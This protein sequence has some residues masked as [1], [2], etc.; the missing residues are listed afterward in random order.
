[1]H[2]IVQLVMANV[3]NANVVYGIMV[4]FPGLL[5]L[6]TYSHVRISTPGQ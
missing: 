3:S 5:L 1:M 2:V 6:K 4:G